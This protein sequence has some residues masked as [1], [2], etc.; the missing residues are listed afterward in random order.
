MKSETGSDGKSKKIPAY[1][2]LYE[3]IKNDIVLGIYEYETKIPS[4]RVMAAKSG[5]SEITVKH[6]YNLLCDEGYLESRE[7]S[8]YFVVFSKNAGFASSNSLELQKSLEKSLQKAS[9]KSLQKSPGSEYENA[10]ANEEFPFSVFTKTVRHVINFYAEKIFQ[11][12][13]NSGCIELRR[14]IRFYLAR[15]RKIYI[16]ESQIVIGS[17]AEYLYSLIVKL[18]GTDRIFGLESP[19]YE[20]IE[21][22]YKM[23][24]A[25]CEFLPLAKDG[26]ETSA[27]L[28]TKASVIHI[29]PYRSFPTGITASASKR[30]EYIAWAQKKGR[31]IVE[32]DFESEFSI[33]T[34]PEETIFALSEKHNAQNVIYLNTFSKTISSALRI[35]YMV[36]PKKLVALFQEKLGFYSCTVPSFD[37]LILADLIESGNFERQIN[38]IRRKKR[39]EGKG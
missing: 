7:R 5:V 32:D 38:R 8:G 16:E 20:Q 24:G 31:F 23:S 11:K 36:L 14:A 34:K 4:K 30:Y 15:N 17:G 1:L 12:S 18:L 6:A 37:Q 25:K 10:L 27:L 35:G 26:I 19:S 3:G 33:S 13:P 2:S 29:S 21:K 39:R 22:V 28:A 9:Q